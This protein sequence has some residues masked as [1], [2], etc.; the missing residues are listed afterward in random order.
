MIAMLLGL[1]NPLNDSGESG[2]VLPVALLSS[3]D[4]VLDIVAIGSHGS[5]ACAISG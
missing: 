1:N 3:V 4:G 5:L 2:T